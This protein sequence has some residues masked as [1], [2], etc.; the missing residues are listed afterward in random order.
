MIYLTSVTLFNTFDIILIASHRD[1]RQIVSVFAVAFDY[2][3]E[4][5]NLLYAIALILG[6]S[7]AK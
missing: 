5:C 2:V 1:I 4:E 3:V 7:A 6:N